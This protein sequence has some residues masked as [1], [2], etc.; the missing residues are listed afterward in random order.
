MIRIG[1]KNQVPIELNGLTSPIF[2]F[3]FYVYQSNE[4]IIDKKDEIDI[5]LFQ[6]DENIEQLNTELRA[7]N[8]RSTFIYYAKTEEDLAILQEL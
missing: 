2:K 4:E 3:K 6:I 5:Y 7:M 8:D 1:V